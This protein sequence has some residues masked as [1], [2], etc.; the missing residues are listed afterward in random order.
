[1]LKIS[2][3]DF[4]NVNNKLSDALFAGDQPVRSTVH[5]RRA[6][7]II[8]RARLASCRQI[9]DHAGCKHPLSSALQSVEF[10]S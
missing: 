4:A 2:E 6:T 3:I 9:R 7:K 5:L 1:L 10:H 8:E